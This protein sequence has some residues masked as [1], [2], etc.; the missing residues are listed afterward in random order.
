MPGV[1]A[2]ASSSAAAAVSPA[3]SS[4]WQACSRAS[5]R[6]APGPE[7]LGGQHEQLDGRQLPSVGESGVGAPDAL[8]GEFRTRSEVGTQLV[9]ERSVGV[10]D[11][12]RRSGVERRE[13]A[14]RE[15]VQHR[16]T[17]ERMGDVDDAPPAAHL[18]V[19]EPV[20]DGLRQRCGEV[21]RRRH[22]GE[23]VEL[24]GAGHGDGTRRAAR[25]PARTPTTRPSTIDA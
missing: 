5:L 23:P 4:Q 1:P 9:A 16:R 8:G 22:A 19:D 15:I 11:G 21:D 18:H 12:C 20:L 2:V 25:S 17:D 7:Q 14:R 3:V 13:T 24:E 10:V 6:A